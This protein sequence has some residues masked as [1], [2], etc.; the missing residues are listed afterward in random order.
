M[1]EQTG[2]A[3]NVMKTHIDCEQVAQIFGKT[4]ASHLE[5][6]PMELAPPA[7]DYRAPGQEMCE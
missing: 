2:T 7:L 1:D 4:Y 5:C 6:R 3:F